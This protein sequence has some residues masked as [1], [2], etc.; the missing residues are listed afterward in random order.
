[1]K[2]IKQYKVSTL[3]SSREINARNKK[4]AIQIFKNQ[5]KNFVSNDDKITVK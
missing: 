1:M 2:S 3:F 4:E 5:L